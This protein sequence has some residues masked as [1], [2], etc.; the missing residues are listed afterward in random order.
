MASI[1]QKM[2]NAA[3]AI[4]TLAYD[5]FENSEFDDSHVEELFADTAYGGLGYL[6]TVA[7]L[8]VKR[9]MAVEGYTEEIHTMISDYLNE[10]DIE[11]LTEDEGRRKQYESL[12]TAL[13]SLLHTPTTENVQEHKDHQAG[14][15]AISHKVTSNIKIP[16]YDGAFG[17]AA[18]FVNE[19]KACVRQLNYDESDYF[20]LLLTHT[21][22]HA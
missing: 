17:K 9:F 4:F 12:A 22:G 7:K 18:I 16:K 3:D 14:G 15:I 5:L 1:Q 13:S 10:V 2:M 6:P 20:S 8:I 11:S 21:E 19:F